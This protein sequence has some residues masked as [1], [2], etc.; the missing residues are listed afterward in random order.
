MM[1]FVFILE[2]AIDLRV[3]RHPLPVLAHVRRAYA[4]HMPV[5]PV[6]RERGQ[7]KLTLKLLGQF[8]GPFRFLLHAL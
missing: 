1:V 2:I 5:Y 6:L 3:S 7:E 8:I 4:E